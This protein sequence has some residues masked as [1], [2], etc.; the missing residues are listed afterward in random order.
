MT[1]R[2]YNEPS[3]HVDSKILTYIESG[4]NNI[5][6]RINFRNDQKQ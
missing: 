2:I 3:F 4:P 1:K 6:K 5:I